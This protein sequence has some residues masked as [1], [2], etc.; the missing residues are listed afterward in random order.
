MRLKATSSLTTS[1]ILQNNQSTSTKKIQI[2]FV[3]QI[4][5]KWG[6]II[7]DNTGKY[8]VDPQFVDAAGFTEDYARVKVGDKWGFIDKTGKNIVNPKFDKARFFSEGL[9]IVKVGGKFGIIDKTGKYVV[10][11]QY[12]T[13]LQ[14]DG[15][16]MSLML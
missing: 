7:I 5:A 16:P 2:V 11:P 3:V 10:N 6:F 9:A 12:D 1:Y 8:V 15:L 14:H 4:G 13:M